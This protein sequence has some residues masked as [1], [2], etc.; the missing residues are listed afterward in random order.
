MAGVL[1]KKTYYLKKKQTI[2]RL[3]MAII[4]VRDKFFPEAIVL[5]EI[6]HENYE[7]YTYLVIFNHL[8]STR[9]YFT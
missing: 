9:L 2:V 6:I 8:F 4:L 7:V 5:I 3:I 1:V